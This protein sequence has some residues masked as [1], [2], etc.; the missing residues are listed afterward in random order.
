MRNWRT[1][2]QGGHLPVKCAKFGEP[3]VVAFISSKHPDAQPPGALRDQ[4]VVGKPPL[5]SN[6]QTKMMPCYSGDTTPSCT[7][8]QRSAKAK[9]LAE[10]RTA[11]MNIKATRTISCG[12]GSEDPCLTN[13]VGATSIIEVEAENSEL[14]HN[15]TKVEPKKADLLL[16]FS[17]KNRE[18]SG[19]DSRPST[20]WCPTLYT[21]SGG[22][23]R[24]F[25]RSATPR[26]RQ[27]AVPPVQAGVP[28]GT[29]SGAF[30]KLTPPARKI[31]DLILLSAKP[32]R[33]D[34]RCG[35]TCFSGGTLCLLTG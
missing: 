27:P 12:D 33:R 21:L 34:H 6:A 32:L 18:L 25:V 29:R 5:L 16:N 24:R 13:D 19:K 14:W 2:L 20:T 7:P 30:R 31:F 35:H 15:L 28:L 1:A 11:G 23:H 17:T 9:A 10:A 3:T 22:F 4:C 26:F 8:A